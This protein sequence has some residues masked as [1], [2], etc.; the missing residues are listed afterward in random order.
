MTKRVGWHRRVL[1]GDAGY[2]DSTQDFC[3]DIAFV[4]FSSPLPLVRHFQLFLMPAVF[5]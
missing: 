2:N 3:F 4:A 5:E 1:G